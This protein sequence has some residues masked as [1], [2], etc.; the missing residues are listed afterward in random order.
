MK[1]IILQS[2][3]QLLA[4]RYILVICLIL[5]IL[6]ISFTVYVGF[7]VHSSDL[8]LVTHYSAYGVTHIYRD[9][10]YY[11]LLF[12]LFGLIVG[13]MHSVIT[14][15]LLVIKGEVLASLFAWLSVVIIIL[16]WATT[17]TVLTVW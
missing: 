7:N 10:W 6:S 3:K 2:I 13:V 5:I 17:V 14:V 12:G 1:T 9:Q 4:N 11:L 8:Q 15:K 16:A